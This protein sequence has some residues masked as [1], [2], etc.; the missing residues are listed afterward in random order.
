MISLKEDVLKDFVN[1]LVNTNP[2]L[3]Q[4]YLQ[5]ILN[6]SGKG[7][8]NSS[9]QHK[10]DRRYNGILL[11]AEKHEL[12]YWKI[13]RGKLWEALTLIGPENEL[14]I[15][16]SEKNLKRIIKSGKGSHYLKLL[17]LFN[18]HLDNQKP[19][20]KQELLD[21]F[22]EEHENEFNMDDAIKMLEILNDK[23]SRVVVFGF[24][25]T[26]KSSVRAYAFNSKNQLVWEQGLSHL[27]DTN[28]SLALSNDYVNPGTKE[29][30]NKNDRKAPEKQ[31]IVRLKNS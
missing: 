13:K 19:I 15:F 11:N 30:N 18:E 8:L 20:F 12:E 22:S 10:W 9:H 17:N 5:S 26:F 28:Y 25:T 16:F 14:Y 23:P 6:E 31:Q 7:T 24:D 4:L 2:E 1:V 3:H 29:S 27:I 21:L